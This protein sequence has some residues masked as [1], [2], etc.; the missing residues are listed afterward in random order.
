MLLADS[1]SNAVV[2]SGDLSDSEFPDKLYKRVKEKDLEKH[3]EKV[4]YLKE[5]YSLTYGYANL[6]A[7]KST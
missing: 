2:I 3:S 4:R 1:M 7:H 6:I 5:H